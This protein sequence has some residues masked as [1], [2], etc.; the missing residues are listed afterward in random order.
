MWEPAA[1]QGRAPARVLLAGGCGQ[2]RLW[3]W[4][5]LS[6]IMAFNPGSMETR[7]L[8]R[9]RREEALL[10]VT[11]PGTELGEPRVPPFCWPVVELCPCSGVQGQLQH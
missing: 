11:A 3:T 1:R 7:W 8:G 10:V 9:A 5:C 4:H 2:R 6:V